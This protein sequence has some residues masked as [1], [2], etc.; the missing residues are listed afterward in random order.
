MLV[1]RN[2]LEADLDAVFE[3]AQGIGP[4]MT[5]LKADRAA[6]RERLALAA[7]SFAGEAAPEDADYLF[8]LEDLDSG[9]VCG[10]S[11]IKAAV[12]VKEAFYNY[13]IATSV[14]ASPTTGLVNRVQSLHLSHDLSGASELCSLYLRPEYRKGSNGRLLSKGR[15]LF[16]AQFPQLFGAKV[17][18]EMR[19]F[20]DEHGAS[21]FWEAVGRPFF[22]MDFHEAD[23]LCGKGDR[24]F[25]E[26][27]VPRL[28]LYTH[29]LGEDARAAIGR[30]HVDTAPARRLL[31][32]E[33]LHFDGYIDIFD[34]GPVLQ[35]KLHDLRA[36]RESRL[37]PARA[38]TPQAAVPTLVAST[39]RHAF[40]VVVADT[41]P[42]APIPTLPQA[43]LDAL[44]CNAGTPLR[45]MPLSSGGLPQRH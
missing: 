41:D 26:H 39:G 34:G 31:E 23:D 4:G 24:L 8:V 13:R 30:T 1:L 28:P 2:A 25:I 7:D 12:G 44:G 19:G 22:H 11:A 33:G 43:A 38:G 10:V 40:R 37:A 42:D 14:H 18:A 32:Q 9:R 35:A 29:L 20:Q 15:L 36:L 45:L 17:F 27:L 21:P 6:L 3:M 16:M 5:T